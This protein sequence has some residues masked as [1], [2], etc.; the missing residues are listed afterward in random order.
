MLLLGNTNVF[1]VK[2][3]NPLIGKDI[4]M[5]NTK[6]IKPNKYLKPIL[7]SLALV[8]IIVSLIITR[9][10]GFKDYGWALIQ[11]EEINIHPYLGYTLTYGKRIN[12]LGF[13]GPL[14]Q[15]NKE[16]FNVGIFGGSVALNYLYYEKDNLRKSLEAMNYGKGRKIKIYS[17]ALGGI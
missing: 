3:Q 10:R 13:D 6:D 2:D 7:L 11:N 8:G 16:H 12:E 9:W 5:I 14:I 17:F 1:F 4:E 15:K